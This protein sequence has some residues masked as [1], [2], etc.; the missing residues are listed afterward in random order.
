ML[1]VIRSRRPPRPGQFERAD[2]DL[3]HPL[4]SDSTIFHREP[5]LGSNFQR[6]AKENDVDGGSPSSLFRRIINFL[7]ISDVPFSKIDV[8]FFMYMPSD[9]RHYHKIADLKLNVSATGANING[10]SQ[11]DTVTHLWRSTWLGESE[12]LDPLEETLRIKTMYPATLDFHYPH[13]QAIA[14]I[15]KSTFDGQKKLDLGSLHPAWGLHSRI[16]QLWRARPESDPEKLHWR[17]AKSAFEIADEDTSCNGLLSF[18]SQDSSGHMIQNLDGTAKGLMS[19]KSRRSHD[20]VAFALT[21]FLYRE[22][23]ERIKGNTTWHADSD[24]LHRAYIA[25]GSNIG[26]RVTLLESACK[27]MEGRN[28]HICRTSALYETKPMYLEDQQ[29]FLNGACEVRNKSRM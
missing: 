22:D 17:L 12:K 19:Y 20:D 5:T 11:A 10:V 9:L 28:I 15:T 26:D 24:L 7:V 25:L 29:P 18:A 8:K 13:N 16:A 2:V 6:I 4:G 21:A 3:F 27:I 14:T 23:Y 1:M